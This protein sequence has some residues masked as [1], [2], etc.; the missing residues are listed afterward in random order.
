MAVTMADVAR[1]AGVSTKTVSNA[2]SGS[3]SVRPETRQRVL[4]T[5]EQLQYVMNRSASSL[6]S[7][8]TGIIGLVLPDL[9]NGYF[10]ELADAVM[11]AAERRGRVVMIRQTRNTREREI[12]SLA[13]AAASSDGLLVNAVALDDDDHDLLTAAGPVVLLGDQMHASPV[14]HVTMHNTAA[15]TA[16][17]RHLLDT[18]R[19]RIAVLGASPQA[20]EG[21]SGLRMAGYRQAHAEVGLPIDESL[22]VDVRLWHRSDG[23]EGLRRLI[24]RGGEFDA[25]FALNDMMAFGAVRVLQ[26]RGFRIPDDVPVAGFDDLEETRFTFPPLTTVDPGLP[27]IADLAVE[28]LVRR[29]EGRGQV[30]RRYFADFRLVERDSTRV[31]TAGRRP[32]TGTAA[33]P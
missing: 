16:M 18:G 33:A 31:R 29:I 25:V 4:D 2:L 17:T 22:I 10:S 27:Q 7:G 26:E 1:A 24:S 8:R 6:R 28:L 13:S 21:S 23:A 32:P 20:N 30:P 5:A 14:D 3:P 12:A 15:A 9:R 11:E 19:R